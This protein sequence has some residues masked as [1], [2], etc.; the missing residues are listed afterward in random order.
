MVNCSNTEPCIKQNTLL[1]V[2]NYMLPISL[3]PSW[4]MPVTALHLSWFIYIVTLLV[5]W[6][7][8]SSAIK[9]RW[10]LKLHEKK[11]QM[12]AIREKL[13]IFQNGTSLR[14]QHRAE[15]ALQWREWLRNK[16]LS[17]QCTV[18]C[19]SFV[20][21]RKRT[22]R[23]RGTHMGMKNDKDKC[24]YSHFQYKWWINSL[25]DVTE[26]NISK[27]NTIQGLNMFCEEC[28]YTRCT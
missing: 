22:D 23:Q 10:L 16:Q 1:D 4:V 8:L 2:G 21:K 24:L 18:T 12:T 25:P 27:A 11:P 7:C 13:Q 9:N 17:H 19:S 15:P 28:Y 6:R 5:E 14:G 26:G 20:E 3:C